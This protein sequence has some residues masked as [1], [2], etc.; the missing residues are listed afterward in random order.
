MFTL[1]NPEG[2]LTEDDLKAWGATYLVYQEEVGESGTLHLQGYVEMPTPVRFSHFVGLE[3]AHFERAKGHPEDCHKYCTKMETRVGGPYIFGKISKGRGARTDLVSLR[4]AIKEGK[5]KLEILDNDALVGTALK[6]VRGMEVCFDTYTKALPREDKRVVFHYGPP[7]TGKTFCCHS[8]DA[9]YFDGGANGFWNGYTGQTC[10]IF[11]EF[12]GSTLRP[13]ELQRVCDVY[14]Y[15]IN[16][17]GGCVPCK[18]CFLLFIL[19]ASARAYYLLDCGYS[20][21]FQLSA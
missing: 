3:G 2:L 11:D 7:G 6:Y 19:L 17:K 5:S 13:L 1:N 9:Y 12:S 16:V 20:Y 14:P 21:L 18:V 4:N 8:A 10:C 15:M